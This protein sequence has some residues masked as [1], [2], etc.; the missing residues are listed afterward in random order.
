MWLLRGLGI[1]G[2]GAGSALNYMAGQMFVGTVMG[3]GA[4][5]LIGAGFLEWLDENEEWDRE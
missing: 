2:L 1:L 4:G 3:L 5:F